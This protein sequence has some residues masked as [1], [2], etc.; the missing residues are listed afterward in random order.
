M[1]YKER[2]TQEGQQSDRSKKKTFLRSTS[3]QPQKEQQQQQHNFQLV[4]TT[5]HHSVTQIDSRARFCMVFPNFSC[6]SHHVSYFFS[7]FNLYFLLFF[8][9]LAS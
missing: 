1:K 4:E 8:F 7:L 9:R 3:E 6:I 2:K 5:S